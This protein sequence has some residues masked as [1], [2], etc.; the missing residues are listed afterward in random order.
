MLPVVAG[1]AG[2][3]KQIVRYSWVMVVTS[4]LLWPVAQT[5]LLYPVAAAV[6]GGAFLL[7]AYRLRGR[8]GPV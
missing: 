3:A 4:L 5:G 7:E 2:V 6:L 1:E 8:V